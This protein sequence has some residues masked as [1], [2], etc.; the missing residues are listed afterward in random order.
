MNYMRT[1][2]CRNC[3]R[4]T[5][6]EVEYDGSA[7]CSLCGCVTRIQ[8]SRKRGDET[9]RQMPAPPRTVDAKAAEK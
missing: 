2:R 1:W 7:K 5:Q 4:S 8:P 9:A 3:G 6:A